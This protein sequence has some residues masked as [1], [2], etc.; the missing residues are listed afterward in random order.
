VGVKIDLEELRRR[1]SERVEWKEGVADVD[2]V[3]RTLVAFAND[4]A[5]IGGGYVVCGAREARDEHGFPRVEWVGL[6]APDLKRVEGQ[7][8]ARC[9][10]K[11]TPPL[12]PLV[13]EFERGPEG[14]RV[15]VFV[16][17]RSSQAHSYRTDQDSGKY[18]I[19]IGR[20]T[21]EAR[22]GLLLRLLSLKGAVE[23]W[24]RRPCPGA[25]VEDLDLV[26][27]RDVLVR[28]KVY[29][30]RRGVDAYVSD[31][32]WNPMVPSMCVREPLTGVL[33]PRNFAV[34]LFGRNERVQALIPGSHTVVASFQGT[35][36]A[37]QQVEKVDVIGNV[38]HQSYQLLTR[39]EM[40]ASVLVNHR[41]PSQPN[42]E[43][44]PLRALKEAV[45]NSVVHRDYGLV[46]PNLVYV[47]Q[48]R[49]EVLSRG[50]FLA[51]A[52]L[53]REGHATT[54]TAWRNQ[55]L[56]WVF[57]KLQ[58]AQALGQGIDIM[59][60]AMKGAGCPRPRFTL[61]EEH[62]TCILGSN[63]AS[64]GSAWMEEAERAVLR[65]D[66]EEAKKILLEMESQEAWRDDENVL[67]LLGHV[68]AEQAAL[69]LGGKRMP[70]RAPKG[71][72]AAELLDGARVCLQRARE[73][74]SSFVMKRS[75][76][77]E[78]ERVQALMP[79]RGA[80]R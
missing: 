66:F 55:S 27:V 74:A 11:V 10:E 49:V 41:F 19:R 62:V 12:T 23:P 25:T 61:G 43:K 9:R 59:F 58:L 33:R 6:S 76:E 70:A 28:L 68:Q 14:R 21:R 30:E 60:R 31:E 38:L 7:V 72:P 3:V 15:L 77:G 37:A 67:Y 13:E 44:Y 36:R 17:P 80:A 5:N 24:D 20:E 54:T 22:N 63:P 53:L 35:D 34:L 8:L 40:E 73:R 56:A 32:E 16:M 45:I 52:S 69:L 75:I 1:E 26:A 78:L 50:C 4:Q 57:E 48:D 39:M 65:R 42:R 51:D 29:D 2:D 18:F 64:W 46:N 47:F 79:R 71:H